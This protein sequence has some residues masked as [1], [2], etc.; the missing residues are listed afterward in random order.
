MA[1][2][3]GVNFNVFANQLQISWPYFKTR[4]GFELTVINSRQIIDQSVKPDINGL[5]DYSAREFRRR[6]LREML[7]S[8]MKSLM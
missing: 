1:G 4:L 8:V 7:M 2:Q 6:N 5:G 3:R